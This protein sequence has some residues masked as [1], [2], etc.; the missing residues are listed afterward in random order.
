MWSKP[1]LSHDRSIE[2]D[3]RR[4]ARRGRRAS[5]G[6]EPHPMQRW[7]GPMPGCRQRVIVLIWL[8]A[9]DNEAAAL[10]RL[11]SYPIA[12]GRPHIPRRS[13]CRNPRSGPKDQRQARAIGSAA[14]RRSNCGRSCKSLL[15]RRQRRGGAL[16]LIADVDAPS[17]AQR[18]P[19]ASPR[20]TCSSATARSRR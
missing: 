15:P 7:K 8:L 5:D 12:T 19:A 14:A 20:A 9:P 13:R 11:R 1:P 10:V 16:A 17:Q 4:H 18:W 6:L 2:L 3:H